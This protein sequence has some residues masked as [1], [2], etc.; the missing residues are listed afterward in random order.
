MG[1]DFLGPLICFPTFL[2]FIL[3]PFIEIFVGNI[4]ILPFY[5]VSPSF[6]RTFESVPDLSFAVAL[7]NNY[8]GELRSVEFFRGLAL[9]LRARDFQG[10]IKNTTVNFIRDKD[11]ESF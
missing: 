3:L 11:M 8:R 2:C 1:L 7:N 5:L 6:G 9:V 4:Y 10:I